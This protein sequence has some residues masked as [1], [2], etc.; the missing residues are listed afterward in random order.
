MFIVQ[1]TDLATNI[2]LRCKF[3]SVPIAL[4]YH[5]KLQN[6]NKNL[7][8]RRLGNV[9]IKAKWE[10]ICVGATTLAQA[11]KHLAE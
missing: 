3:L 5:L 10:T 4:A 2:G 11:S 1:A 7:L 8:N 9:Q 6:L